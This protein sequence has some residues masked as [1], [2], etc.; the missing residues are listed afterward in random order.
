[1]L[2]AVITQSVRKLDNLLPSHAAR[3]Q[4]QVSHGQL[5]RVH[6][7][8]NLLFP[9]QRTMYQP[10]FQLHEKACLVFHQKG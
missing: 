9:G 1:M 2:A 6:S 5:P 3:E 7:Y 8:N 10:V 4:Q